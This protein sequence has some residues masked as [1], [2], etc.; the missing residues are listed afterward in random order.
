[1][2]GHAVDSPKKWTNKFV[3]FAVKSKK[4]NKTNSFIPFFGGNLL[5]TDCFRFYLTFTLD[6]N[7]LQL[8][9]GPHRTKQVVKNLYNKCALFLTTVA[10]RPP[11]VART[12]D[13]ETCYKKYQRYKIYL[14]R[15]SLQIHSLEIKDTG[16]SLATKKK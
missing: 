14:S 10:V 16:N 13:Q 8:F 7:I 5:H 11:I 3:L 12:K 4:A 6:T 15:T 2:F 1:M 9:F